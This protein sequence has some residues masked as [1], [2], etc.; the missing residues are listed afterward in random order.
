MLSCLQTAFYENLIPDMSFYVKMYIKYEVPFFKEYDLT[1]IH[2]LCK[3]MTLRTFNPG[4]VLFISGSPAVNIFIILS[5]EV[6]VYT[7]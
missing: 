2:S 4:E 1:T 7:D 5:G 3:V 6:G